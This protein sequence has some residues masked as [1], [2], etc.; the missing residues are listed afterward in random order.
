MLQT[1]STCSMHVLSWKCIASVKL[2]HSERN[3]SRLRNTIVLDVHNKSLSSLFCLFHHFSLFLRLTNFF[4]TLSLQLH[5]NQ[6]PPVFHLQD[7]NKSC[8][9]HFVGCVIYTCRKSVL[10]AQRA[11]F[12]GSTVC[13]VQPEQCLH[14]L[15]I[16]T[17]RKLTFVQYYDVVNTEMV[18][19]THS[20]HMDRLQRWDTKSTK[21]DQTPSLKIL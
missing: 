14:T 15:C 7:K 21:K 19:S 2:V 20:I 12:S 11:K 6:H 16:D 9:N 17:L 13:A 18:S 4:R 1:I 10:S 8:K 3:P 5:I